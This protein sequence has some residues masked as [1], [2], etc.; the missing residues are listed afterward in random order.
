MSNLDKDVSLEPDWTDLR[1][2]MSALA[3]VT[4]AGLKAPTYSQLSDNGAGSTGLYAAAYSPTQEQELFFMAQLPHGWQEG[5]D[6]EPHIHWSPSAT[7]NTGNVIWGLEYT[8]TNID[9]AIGNSTIITLTAAA[10]GT[11]RKNVMSDYTTIDATGKTISSQ[12]H[13]RIF[14][15]ATNV[16]DTYPDPSFLLELDFH[17]RQDSLGSPLE[18]SK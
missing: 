1:V 7:A 17:Y 4:G 5:T 13:G 15:D 6:I 9:G 16:L 18:H 14:R 12:I 3:T 11:G 8:W 10:D 2:P